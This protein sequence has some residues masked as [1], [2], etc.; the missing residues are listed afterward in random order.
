MLDGDPVLSVSDSLVVEGDEA[1]VEFRLTEPAAKDVQIRFTL[2]DGSALAGPDYEPLSQTLFIAKGDQSAELAIA[3]VDD[4]IV[5]ATEDFQLVVLDVANATIGYGQS[6]IRIL[7]ND[8]VIRGTCLSPAKPVQLS[9][10]PSEN[11]HVFVRTNGVH[12]EIVVPYV[13]SHGVAYRTYGITGMQSGNLRLLGTALGGNIAGDLH[14][15]PAF[16]EDDGQVEIKVSRE[17]LDNIQQW[18]DDQEDFETLYGYYP[19]SVWWNNCA[20]FVCEALSQGS[21]RLELQFSQGAEGAPWNDSDTVES[22]AEMA[23]DTYTEFWL[24]IRTDFICLTSQLR[25]Q[26]RRDGDVR[27]AQEV[28]RREQHVHKNDNRM[29]YGQ[30]PVPYEGWSN[31]NP[32]EI[33]SGHPMT[34]PS[35]TPGIVNF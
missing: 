3:T 11:L 9:V 29:F 16:P 15:G 21:E 23:Q 34:H 14:I 26:F 6:Q 35:G 12:S 5:E 32:P 18:L 30:A 17:E 1:T 27:I 8:T 4:K 25:E 7:D 31:A 22:K 10:V 24:R 28:R 33:Q 2:K 20:D 19:Y 13:G